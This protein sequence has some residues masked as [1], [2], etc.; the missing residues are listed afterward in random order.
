MGMQ[1]KLRTDQQ[2]TSIAY[3]AVT[4][5]LGRDEAG[6]LTRRLVEHWRYLYVAAVVLLVLPPCIVQ[7]SWLSALAWIAGYSVY[8]LILQF[9]IRG[10]GFYDRP[11]FRL[12]RI[13]LDLLFTAA[14]QLLVPRVVAGYS[15]VLYLVPIVAAIVYFKK[16]YWVGVVLGETYAALA[17]TAVMVGGFG[18]LD[19]PDLVAKCLILTAVTLVLGD[20]ISDLPQLREDGQALLEASTTLI[21]VMERHDLCQLISDAAKAGIPGADAAVVHLLGGEEGDELVPL[22]SSSIDL[23]TL[24]TTLMKRGEGIAG[25]ALDRRETINVSDVGKDPRFHDFQSSH[26][27][28]KS[29]MVASMYVG[30]KDIGTISVHSGRKDAFRTRDER[31]LTTLGAQGG[32][33]LANAELFAIRRRRREMLG[34]ILQASRS[35][36]VNL[37]VE[38]LLQQ[39]AVEACRCTVFQMAVVNL[40]DA[41]SGAVVVG[42]TAGVPPEGQEKLRGLRIPTEVI[43]PLLDRR[44]QVSESYFIRHDHRPEVAALERYTFTPEPDAEQSGGWHPRDMLIVPMRTPDA[45]LV[46][47]ISVDAPQNGQCPSYDTVQALELLASLAAT[48]V[49]NTRLYERA[50]REVAER[51]RAEESLERERARLQTFMDNVDDHIYFKDRDSRFIRINKAMARW[52]GLENASSAIGRTDHDVFSEEHARQARADELWV[53][54]TGEVLRREERETWA[55]GRETWV[56]TV[57]FPWYDEDGQVIGTYGVSRDI[58]DRVRQ[59]QRRRECQSALTSSVTQHTSLEGLAEYIVQTGTR[60]LGA[61]DCTL[62]VDMKGQGELQLAATTLQAGRVV[63]SASSDASAP[64]LRVSDL[65]GR[66]PER[67][68]GGELVSHPV[69]NSNFWADLT[70]DGSCAEVHSLLASPLLRPNGRCAGYL[71]A[72]NSQHSS[73]FTEFDQELLATLAGHAV[74][75]VDRIRDVSERMRVERGRLETDLHTAM[76]LLATG[77]KWEAE[78]ASEELERGRLGKAIEAL[79]RLYKAYQGAYAELSFVLDD[80]LDPTLEREGLVAAL[81]KKAE[82]IARDHITVLCDFGDRLSPELEGDLYRIGIEGMNNA[83]KHAGIKDDPDGRVMV[84]LERSGDRLRLWVADNGDGFDVAETLARRRGWGLQR[85]EAIVEGQAGSLRIWS[86][87]GRGTTMCATVSSGRSGVVVQ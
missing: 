80:L 53:M 49:T 66:G 6:R 85:I 73:G 1:A 33:A 81:R 84:L 51:R 16:S 78:I 19:V 43:R 36:S 32:L 62:F 7:G 42:G 17:F 37:S 20:L 14:L 63:S 25:H 41:D 15:W 65:A 61:Q 67:L 35:F 45:V 54:D 48:A 22:G 39:V 58:T 59:D 77:V 13:E 10:E 83:V 60:L 3:Q 30:D 52:F 40:V 71:V 28:F 26:A 23:A 27:A 44:Y 69:W 87:Q 57:K 64:M 75:G 76:N 5:L 70:G 56:S 12:L 31:L 38:A 8:A 34:D 4:L 21:R 79:Q 86:G 82:L 55:S 11:R 2:E 24:G 46:G 47:Y 9:V 50:Q 72:R 29:L 18:W 68:V 74:A